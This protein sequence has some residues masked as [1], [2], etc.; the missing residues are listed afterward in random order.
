MLQR[1]G[2]W[3][4][5]L[6]LLI[7]GLHAGEPAGQIASAPKAPAS[8]Q[9][10]RWTTEDGLPQNRIACLQQTRDGYLWLGSWFGLARFDGA[11]F[12]VFN[13]QN[14]PML[15]SDTITA[16]AEDADGALWIGTADGLVKFQ[17]GV[18]QR[19]T[20]TNG[21]PA[22]RIEKIAPAH[23]GGIWLQSGMAVV[24]GQAGGF[25][26]VWNYPEHSRLIGL[27]EDAAGHLNLF[28]NDEWR[29]WT[30][31]LP[32]GSV[33]LGGA[34]EMFFCATPGRNVG[35]AFAGTA[36][37]LR[38]FKVGEPSAS[39]VGGL[40]TNRV[41]FCHAG[42]DG[43]V[44]AQSEALVLKCWDGTA[45]SQLDLGVGKAGIVCAELDAQ[46]SVW[47]GTTEGLVRLQ[48]PKVRTFAAPEGLTNDNVWSVCA[49][50]DG[51]IWLGTDRGL[52]RINGNLVESFALAGG[53]VVEPI[54]SVTVARAGGI[55]A[56]TSHHGL[57]KM[58]E[59]TRA[60]AFNASL[61]GTLD[62]LYE[63]NAGRLWI[64]T[65]T[66]VFWVQDE[67]AQTP[68]GTEAL[69]EVHAILQDRAG[70]FWFGLKSGGLAQWRDGDLKRFSVPGASPADGVWSL[71]ED[72]G[73]ALW[74]GTERGLVRFKDGRFFQFA[75]QHQLPA[76]AVNWVLEDGAGCL[77]CS[78]L[79]GIFRVPRADLEAVAEGRAAVV[80]PFILG[81]ADGMKSPE[82]N[83]GTQPAGWKAPDG[84]LWFA[85][86]KGVVVID[87][88]L[89]SETEAPPRALLE[90]L[91]ADGKEIFP[92]ESA[93]I[94][95]GAGCG[96]ALE[97]RFTACDL[98]APEAVRFQTRLAGVA[99]DWSAPSA[100]RAANYFNL[101]P[102]TFRFEVRAMD[103]HGQWSAP[104]ALDFFLAPCFWQTFWFYFLC[105]V[106][107]IG[108]AGGV[109]AYRLRWQHRLLKLEQQRA[110]A[111]E[112]TRIARDLHDDLGTALTGLA[113]ELDQ[114][115]RSAQKVSPLAERL[116]KA[117]EHTRQLAGRM[118]EVVWVVNPR[119]DNL[120][121][122][123]D[124]L[125]DQAA[126]LLRASGLDVRLD[127][128][129]EIPELPVAANV[130]HQL[131]LSVREA[132]ANLVRHAH[133]TQA[134]VRLEWIAGWLTVT[135]RDHG[136]GFAPESPAGA[137]H[138][139]NNMRQRMA[140]IG[141]TFECVSAPGKGTIITFKVSLQENCI[142][143]KTT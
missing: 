136:C 142:G 91:K 135:I 117:S 34:E 68:P 93:K 120:R 106:G 128:P 75:A 45:W 127:F 14:T 19:F 78:T 61:S 137:E 102:G 1:T 140:E 57:F 35:Q 124:F 131:A 77:W 37:G 115:G 113:L 84:R 44:W 53:T 5:L 18:F 15:G 43:R 65:S 30:N 134:E 130:R 121:S 49:T 50:A 73:G 38:Q 125:E 143:E 3:I 110:L 62:A 26:A 33:T 25:T 24:R 58:P 72:A 92:P 88:K 112:R 16:L 96:H 59:G 80:Q 12:T 13:T 90:S 41:L 123:A 79:H 126:Q 97:F 39:L 31:N 99:A 60:D 100:N 7:A 119:C 21:L 27:R 55:W 11:R 52:A 85:T 95:I 6:W 139:I 28:L 54:R 36:A 94:R 118:R 122:L 51:N 109:Q 2:Q 107:A 86:G 103:H 138:G 69:R 132:F 9:I 71:H 70:N 10:R 64:G 67:K 4:F 116:A 83:G 74:L 114:I 8:H 111:S 89:F 23:A 101:P 40:E 87:P 104:A 129:A 32:S 105:A 56:A 133:A 17:H 22:N 98:A 66:G 81:T 63:D 29:V 47:F 141:G 20:T 46:G 42:R 76:D 82:S 108:V 48:S